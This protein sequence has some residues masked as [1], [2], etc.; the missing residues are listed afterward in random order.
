MPKA[1][2]QAKTA[3]KKSTVK[4][5]VAVSRATA[6]ER[7]FI[8][9]YPNKLFIYTQAAS[10]YWWVRLYVG[11]RTLVKTTKQTD[12]RKAT[13]FAKEFYDAAMYN[14]RRGIVSGSRANFE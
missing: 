11:G 4:E 6:T 14:H 12:Q 3:V 9:G 5:T 7:V 10:K 13:A 2:T 8:N 1:T